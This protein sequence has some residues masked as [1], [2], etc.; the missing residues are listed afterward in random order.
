MAESKK[1]EEV[2]IEYT[3]PAFPPDGINVT[4]Q[5]L[6][7]KDAKGTYIVINGV[8]KY[9]KIEYIKTYFTPLDGEWK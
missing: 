3:C 1:N 9:E 6:Y 7:G 5:F 8:K 2:I 4:D